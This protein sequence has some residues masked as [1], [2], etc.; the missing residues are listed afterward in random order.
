MNAELQT[1]VDRLELLERQNRGWKLLALAAF[2]IALSAIV[3]PLLAPAK[4]PASRALYSVVE[5][6]RF[7]LRDPDGRL[8]GGMEVGRDHTVKL[9]LGGGSA[10]GS[11]AFLQVHGSGVVDLTMRGPDGSVRAALLATASPSLSLSANGRH[12]AVTAMAQQDGAGTLLLT[13]AAG[14]L[15]FRAP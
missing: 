3:W 4:S 6:N 5:A 14:G 9:V 8:A 10:H 7:L 15:R 11:A 1:V 2:V 13:D 12:S